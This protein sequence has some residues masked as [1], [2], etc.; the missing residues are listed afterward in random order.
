MTKKAELL[1][2]AGNFEKLK[3]AVLYGA[4]AVYLAGRDFGLRAFAA[5]FDDAELTEAVAYAH[6]QG[7][8]V[9]V[10][11]NILA[12]PFDLAALP[13]R[14]LFLQA[15]GVDAVI[16]SDAGIFRTVRQ[17]APDME[18]H[19]STQASVTNAEACL[20][21]YE[22]GARRVV[23]ARELSLRE[24]AAIRQAIPADMELEAFTHG[25]MC[26]AWSGR[27]LLS[28]VATGR[29]ANRGACAQPCRWK[30][31]V[32]ESGRLQETVGL[33]ETGSLDQVDPYTWEIEADESGSFIF[34]SKDICMVDHLADMLAA[35]ISSFKI[36]G[37]MKSAYYTAVTTKV[38]K[39]AL[40]AA[41]SGLPESEAVRAARRLE[42][43][44]MVHRQFDTGFYYDHPRDDAK[45]SPDRISYVK[46]TVVA[47]IKAVLPDGRLLC[48]QR[49]KL[50][51]GDRL[52]IIMPQGDNVSTQV[53]AL[54]NDKGQQ[55]GACPHPQEEFTLLADLGGVTPV[56][57]SLI[58]RPGGKYGE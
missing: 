43:E 29:D 41:L 12:G 19:I 18:I 20:F 45:I 4:D 48:E 54:Y 35:G 40:T 1:A 36:E 9:Y 26:M 10:T 38:Y 55:V 34:S 8:K 2:P 25:A 22:A 15:A 6:S 23:L 11:L 21:W 7:V 24:I 37:R 17:L 3:T 53:K 50:M 51:V 30:Y 52:D 14:V 57:G 13:D 46:A 44:S 28:N 16:V 42:L 33:S 58:R 49:N 56:P 27:C 31:H 47:I 32:T 5:N 39:E